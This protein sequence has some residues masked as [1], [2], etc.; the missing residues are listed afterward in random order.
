MADLCI[1]E[2]VRCTVCHEPEPAAP[3]SRPFEARF[4][5]TCQGCGFSIRPGDRVRYVTDRLHHA[6]HRR[7]AQE[8]DRG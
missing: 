2:V 3:S 8:A 6:D 1:H 4:D 5:G 7:C